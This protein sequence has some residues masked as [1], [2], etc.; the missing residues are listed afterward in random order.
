MLNERR[1][2]ILKDGTKGWLL[3]IFQYGSVHTDE[4]AEPLAVIELEDGTI[5]DAITLTSCHFVREVV[6]DA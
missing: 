3:G 1:K 4:G 2:I 5:R 6:Q